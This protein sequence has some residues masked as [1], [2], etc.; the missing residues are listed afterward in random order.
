MRMEERFQTPVSTQ[1]YLL[2][3]FISPTPHAVCTAHNSGLIS[4]L[5]GFLSLDRWFLMV[6]A[7]LWVRVGATRINEL[8]A[9]F[10]RLALRER[11]H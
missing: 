2:N 10:N 6:L 4:L 7:S 11:A 5:A 9:L 8:I 3:H 1:C